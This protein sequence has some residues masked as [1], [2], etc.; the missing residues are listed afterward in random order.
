MKNVA[1]P[2]GTLISMNIYIYIYTA[3]QNIWGLVFFFIKE[4]NAFIQQGQIKLIKSDKNMYNITNDFYL[5]CCFLTIHQIIHQI[6][7]FAEF[8]SF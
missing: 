8:N 6:L 4:F 3:V 2:C 7:Q 1:P 5:K